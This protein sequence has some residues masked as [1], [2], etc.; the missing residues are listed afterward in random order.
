[1]TRL[2]ALLPLKDGVAIDVA[3]TRHA[4]KAKTTG[5]PRSLGQIKAAL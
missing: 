1:M 5:D 4:Q 3:L 2:S